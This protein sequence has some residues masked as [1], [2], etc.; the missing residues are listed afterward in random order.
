MDWTNKYKKKGGPSD[1]G[2]S[3]SKDEGPQEA[4]NLRTK[5]KRAFQLGSRLSG[6]DNPDEVTELSSYEGDSDSGMDNDSGME[7]ELSEGFQA[8]RAQSLDSTLGTEEEIP[9]EDEDSTEQAGQLEEA[10]QEAQENFDKYLR[11]VAE[12][13]NYKKR[14]IKE[15]ADLL[16]YA[17][18]HIARDLVDVADDFERALSHFSDQSSEVIDGVKL[19]YQSFC[20]VLERHA[21]A[22]VDCRGKAFDPEMQEALATVPSDEVEAGMVVEQLRKAYKFKDKLLRPAQVVV[23]VKPASGSNQVSSEPEDSSEEN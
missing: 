22:G 6:E 14:A 3:F 20:K 15:R 8:D 11:A 1:A 9:D 4:E 21:I 18:E 7:G 2:G 10:K 16:R 17:G 19:I 13:E 12:L 5:A 23:S